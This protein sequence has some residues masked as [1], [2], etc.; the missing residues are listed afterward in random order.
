MAATDA[1][2]LDEPV[3]LGTILDEDTVCIMT[4]S[5]S[6]ACLKADDSTR[7]LDHMLLY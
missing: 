1:I 3:R 6:N 7:L 5:L 2:L 4:V